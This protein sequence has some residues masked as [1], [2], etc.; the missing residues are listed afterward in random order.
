ML[1]FTSSNLK[2]LS[3]KYSRKTIFAQTNLN[4]NNFKSRVW[5]ALIEE[6]ALHSEEIAGEKEMTCVRGYHVSEGM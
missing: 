2:F 4:E 3:K 1:S 6:I 5:W